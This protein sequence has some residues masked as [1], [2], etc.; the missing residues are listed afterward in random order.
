MSRAIKAQTCVGIFNLSN[1][2]IQ[3]DV[4]TIRKSHW[5]TRVA[6]SHCITQ[7][8]TMRPLIYR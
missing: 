4:E 5:N 3:L 1:S 8:I 7:I 6:I 2:W